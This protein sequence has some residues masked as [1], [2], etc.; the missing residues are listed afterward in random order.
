MAEEERDDVLRANRAV[1]FEVDLSAER[2]YGSIIK[3][4][5]L[6]AHRPFLSLTILTLGTGN[7]T[8]VQRFEDGSTISYTQAELAS[9]YVMDREYID[10]LIN[11]AVQAVTNPVLLVEWRVEN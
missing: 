5:D 4:F 8:L 9:G 10:I 6:E 7:F 1:K 2:Q 3:E 11:N